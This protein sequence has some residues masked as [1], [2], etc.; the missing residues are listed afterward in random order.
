R[1]T[2]RGAKENVCMNQPPVNTVT[3]R[4][5]TTAFAMRRRRTQGVNDNGERNGIVVPILTLP[6]YAPTLFRNP[7]RRKASLAISSQAFANPMPTAAADCGNRLV[8]V[9]PGSVFTSRQ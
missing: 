9:I 8:P 7:V 5:Y 4:K 2:T 6:C 3:V 1:A